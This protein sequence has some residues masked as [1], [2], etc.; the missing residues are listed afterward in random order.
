MRFLLNILLLGG[1]LILA[2]PAAAEDATPESNVRI[3]KAFRFYLDADGKHTLSPSLLDR[4]AYQAELRD[5]PERVSGLRFEVQWR[6]RLEVPG[7]VTVRV[8]LRHGKGNTV[9]T[10]TQDQTQELKKK[11]RRTHWSRIQVPTEAY[12]ELG[13]IVAW[14]V[15]LWQGDQQLAS[16]ESF[17]W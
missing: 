4:D 8:E 10:Y 1:S 12:A 9:K 6:G 2:A 5:N 15:T 7:S 14:R 16:Q 3:L 17:L 11:R 13:D